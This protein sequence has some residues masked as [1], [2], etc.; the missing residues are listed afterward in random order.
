MVMQA[1]EGAGPSV[2]NVQLYPLLIFFPKRETLWNINF[3]Q[4]LDFSYTINNHFVIKEKIWLG[5]S[6][7]VHLTRGWEEAAVFQV[8][9]KLFKDNLCVEI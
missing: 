6:R 8:L 9:K 4:E 7:W 5:D 3:N 2:R 1:F